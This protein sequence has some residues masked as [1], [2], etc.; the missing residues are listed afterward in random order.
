[1]PADGAQRVRA[2][3]ISTAPKSASEVRQQVGGTM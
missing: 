1:M 3:I 2:M